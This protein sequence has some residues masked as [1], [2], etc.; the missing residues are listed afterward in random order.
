MADI[1]DKMRAGLNKGV[2]TISTGSKTVV[3]KTK[4]NSI[5]NNLENEKKRL[6]EEMGMKIYEFCCENSEGDFPRAESEVFYNQI[7][8]RN[9]QIEEQRNKLAELDAEM[10][11]VLGTQVTVTSVSE[12]NG[13]TCA[14]GYIN[15]TGAKFCAKCGQG[16]E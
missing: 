4:I 7:T 8:Q 9:I 16:L 5:I 10:N 1:F 13:K 12:N 2:A 14:C 6:C 3:E 15:A 11:R